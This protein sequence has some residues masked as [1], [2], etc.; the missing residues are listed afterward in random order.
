M[1]KITMLKTMYSKPPANSNSSLMVG[2]LKNEGF[3]GKIGLWNF[4]RIG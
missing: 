3:Q 2:V 4:G 1:G